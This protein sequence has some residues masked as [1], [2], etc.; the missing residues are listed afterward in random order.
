MDYNVYVC[1]MRLTFDLI[2]IED[3]NKYK[4]GIPSGYDL[5]IYSDGDYH[6]K[7]ACILYGF[8]EI[9]LFED[10]YVDPKYGFLKF[11]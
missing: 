3:I 8:D 4:G 6:M 11:H 10:E 5:V 2:K 1:G 7:D 9:G